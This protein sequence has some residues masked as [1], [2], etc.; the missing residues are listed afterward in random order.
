MCVTA[1]Y[2]STMLST[3]TE[4][5][6]TNMKGISVSLYAFVLI[7]IGSTLGPLAAAQLNGVLFDDPRMLGRSLA[8]IGIAALILS[9]A[10]TLVA[11]QRFTKTIARGGAF[12]RVV[13]ANLR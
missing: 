3:M 12:A 13:D 6:P 5:V 2:G 9:A 11:R 7:M 8:I 10:L 4:L 1:V